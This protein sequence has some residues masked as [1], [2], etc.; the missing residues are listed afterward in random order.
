MAPI[1]LASYKTRERLPAWVSGFI[2]L[3]LEYANWYALKS[4]RDGEA[5]CMA[6]A[7]TVRFRVDFGNERSIGVG[8]IE[9]LEY[10]ARTG[11]LSQAARDLGMSYRRAWLLVEDMKL[12]FDQPVVRSSAG[13]ANGGGAALTDFGERLLARYRTLESEIQSLARTSLWDIA[14]HTASRSSEDVHV[15]SIKRR[16]P[17]RE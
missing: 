4:F 14:V 10:I 5:E 16:L 7:L 9:L 17:V 15:T 12:S 11:S 2:N 8:K 6:K 3:A 1:R 13:G